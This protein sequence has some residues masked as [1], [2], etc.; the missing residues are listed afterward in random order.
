MDVSD[1]VVR[2]EEGLENGFF[3]GLK[4]F[5]PLSILD[6][7]EEL[8]AQ[9]YEKVLQGKMG[10]EWQPSLGRMLK[11]MELNAMKKESEVWQ[12]LRQLSEERL[13]RRRDKSKSEH[14]TAAKMDLGES[15]MPRLDD[16]MTILDAFDQDEI[17]K[18]VDIIVQWLE[19]Q[20]A[21][22]FHDD[23]SRRSSSSQSLPH[24]ATTPSSAANRRFQPHSSA[25]KFHSSLIVSE[26]PALASRLDLNGKPF[27]NAPKA[28]ESSHSLA[29]SGRDDASSNLNPDAASSVDQQLNQQIW[30]LF[31]A[32]QLDM[33]QSMLQKGGQSA[34][35]ASFAPL[36]S[37]L[38]GA[39]ADPFLVVHAPD[40][41]SHQDKS[42]SFP[43]SSLSNMMN[44]DSVPSFSPSAL[45]TGIIHRSLMKRALTTI[46]SLA[47]SPS[48]HSEGANSSSSSRS[49]NRI[50]LDAYER[51]LYS[52]LS[53]FI[54]GVLPVCETWED[55]LW[56]FL[57]IW[58]HQRIDR[59]LSSPNSL[60]TTDWSYQP[61]AQGEL[62]WAIP[63]ASPISSIPQASPQDVHN[64]FA[65]HLSRSIRQFSG[66]AANGDLT[67]Q[68][69][70]LGSTSIER[71]SDTK[72]SEKNSSSVISG[73]ATNMN[74]P[75]TKS[76]D[77]VLSHVLGSSSSSTQPSSQ[78]S[79]E[80][81]L[82]SAYTPYTSPTDSESLMDR[83]REYLSAL[84]AG[85]L[86]AFP[87]PNTN[88][89]NPSTGTTSS[90][91]VLKKVSIEAK[92]AFRTIESYIILQSWH[93][94]FSYLRHL[95]GSVITQYGAQN[96][97]R[98]TTETQH[99]GN[100][101]HVLRFAAH[102]V[103]ALESI[104]PT[105]YE[106]DAQ[107]TA[108]KGTFGAKEKKLAT[109]R[110]KPGASGSQSAST[111]A[112]DAAFVIAK[113]VEHLMDKEG[114]RH[115]VA[116]YCARMPPSR[117]QLGYELYVTM[118]RRIRT[119]RERQRAIEEAND[120][121][122]DSA[123]ITSLLVEDIISDP[124]FE[125]ASN[126][127]LGL[128]GEPMIGG[129]T[130]NA[131][132]ST[133]S[134]VGA[135]SKAPLPSS[136]GK[137]ISFKLTTR[138]NAETG[139]ETPNKFA[140]P[141]GTPG[142]LAGAFVASS[143]SNGRQ[144]SWLSL[145]VQ[146]EPTEYLSKLISLAASCHSSSV[147][148]S[149]KPTF[150]TSKAQSRNTLDEGVPL[151]PVA[152]V[153]R[154]HSLE[155][156]VLSDSDE[157]QKLLCLKHANALARSFI[158]ASN[159][160]SARLLF[161]TVN[162]L[163]SGLFSKHRL[164]QDAYDGEDY[165][166]EILS[167]ENSS[168]MSEDEGGEDDNVKNAFIA[169]PKALLKEY[170]S[171]SGFLESLEAFSRWY[172]EGFGQQRSAKWISRAKA[173]STI[174]TRNG[175]EFELFDDFGFEQEG[176]ELNSAGQKAKSPVSK[177]LAPGASQ[178]PSKPFSAP[179]F[180]STAAEAIEKLGQV[181]YY[182]AG[183][184]TEASPILSSQLAHQCIVTLLKHRGLNEAESSKMP[185]SRP[186]Q[187]SL[188]LRLCIPFSMLLL[189][190]TLLATHRLS[191]AVLLC[192]DLASDTQKLFMHCS[193]VS[194]QAF[195]VQVHLASLFHLHPSTGDSNG[196]QPPATVSSNS[197]IP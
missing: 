73:L 64:N 182:P 194:I 120:A 82:N 48:A 127:P 115:L 17:L 159:F 40:L 51:A 29:L 60:N 148:S 185:R 128:N 172:H 77:S 38:Q 3:A 62:I 105:I 98:V 32:G 8:C 170:M 21:G 169:S 39:F 151:P 181:V 121:G 149:L 63:A 90:A 102:L 131:L 59:V 70:D 96:G 156:L 99:F 2:F 54:G 195:L 66:N 123:L 34:R 69:S 153:E 23:T 43:S 35:F 187:I 188:L 28:S 97:Q 55:F 176:E 42:H 186:S 81:T 145:L 154:I 155:W 36:A 135:I 85:Q 84:E 189:Q 152:D 94:L 93:S 65:E 175:A 171:L 138:S 137:P 33:A 179:V 112:D 22:V 119:T 92:E 20:Y 89:S 125:T 30:R 49:T 136:H 100:P 46:S 165:A 111:L 116:Q 101:S 106:D 74:L 113:Y 126:S 91:T 118:M 104:Y 184:L 52:C 44:L 124:S 168:E 16:K 166:S 122:L 95:C 157:K 144:E 180:H 37:G 9:E 68:K 31:R 192:N 15:A 11:D 45:P 173:T 57:K 19:N 71:H 150:I 142:A 107:A 41:F 134:R 174:S 27:K 18:E 177:S 61:S 24:V 129:S 196:T 193:N 158:L 12:L 83:L 26:A 4:H 25:K 87:V 167:D 79:R 161:N 132:S 191:D 143:Q 58:L 133:P 10:D 7:F 108:K 110:S 78:L 162:Q 75:T 163:L 114:C 1:S 140:R 47:S 146:S 13:R 190:H 160:A 6:T 53:G 141:L 14:K 139:S 80:N 76:L 197:N 50:T 88:S 56:V 72:G 130:Q 103:L 109:L 178:A 67:L 5:E 147:A 183:W 164:D 86:P 117:H